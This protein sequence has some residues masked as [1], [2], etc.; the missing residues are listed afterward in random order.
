MNWAG[1]DEWR[2]HGNTHKCGDCGKTWQD[3]EGGCTYCGEAED[4]ESE[5]E[6]SEEEE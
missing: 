5:D 2:V 6:E 1:Y 4:E 3:F